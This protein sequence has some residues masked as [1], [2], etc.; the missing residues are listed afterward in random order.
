M[1]ANFCTLEYQT[2]EMKIIK[3][4]KKNVYQFV[5]KVSWHLKEYSDCS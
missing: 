5:S 4:G 3:L 1:K 2:L